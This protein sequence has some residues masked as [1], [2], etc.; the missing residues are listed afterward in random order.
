[1]PVICAPLIFAKNPCSDKEGVI[2]SNNNFKRYLIMVKKTVFGLFLTAFLLVG[3]GGCY[4]DNLAELHPELQCDPN[5]TVSFADDIVPILSGSCS[6]A[7]ADCHASNG[8]SL[9]PLN[10]YNGVK[11]QVDNGK[12]L[13][14]IIWDGNASFMPSGSISKIDSC[15]MSKI[16]RWIAAGAPNN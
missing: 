4:Y 6:S 13:S 3:M 14:S 9:K 1:M 12:L 7:S 2:F 8:T 15:S 11:V 5:A 16:S 10:D